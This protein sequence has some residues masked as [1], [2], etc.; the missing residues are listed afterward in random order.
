M[1]SSISIKI[2][3]KNKKIHFMGLSICLYSFWISVV[4]DTVR[5]SVCYIQVTASD[6]TAYG[7]V[8]LVIQL[9]AQCFW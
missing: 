5:G 3:K 4:S 6:D 9:L 7:V 1:Q 2:N 8:S